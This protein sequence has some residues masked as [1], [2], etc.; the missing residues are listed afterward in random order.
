MDN[1]VEL[2]LAQILGINN[3]IAKKSSIHIAEK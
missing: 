1:F 2:T 3:C